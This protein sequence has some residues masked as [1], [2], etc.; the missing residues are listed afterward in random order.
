MIYIIPPEFLW[1]VFF[2]AGVGLLLC[3]CIELKSKPSDL[4]LATLQIVLGLILLYVTY[5]L[6]KI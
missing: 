6:Y 3:G 5:E 4:S 1:L 2:P